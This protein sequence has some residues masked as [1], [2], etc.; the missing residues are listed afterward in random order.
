MDETRLRWAEVRDARAIAILELA[1]AAYEHRRLP[2]DFTVP[3]FTKIWQDRIRSYQY[4]TILCE[5]K[6]EI[7]G[8]LSFYHQ[9]KRGEICCLYISPKYFRQG[10]GRRLMRAASLLVRKLQGKS[11]KVEVEVLNFGAQAFYQTLHF[12]AHG[13]KLSHLIEMKKEL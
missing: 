6:G 11:L 10:I 12:R 9:V 1:S 3:E 5:K 2:L 8:F 13:V 7:L 4:Q